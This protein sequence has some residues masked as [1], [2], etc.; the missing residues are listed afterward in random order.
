VPS[1]PIRGAAVLPYV[2]AGALGPVPG[3]MVIVA[4][5]GFNLWLLYTA[6]RPYK[7]EGEFAHGDVHV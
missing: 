4:V 1:G 6:L 5:A 7:L 3:W 2:I